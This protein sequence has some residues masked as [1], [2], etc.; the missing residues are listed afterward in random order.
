MLLFTALVQA[1]NLA[2]HVC[3][4]LSTSRRR[5]ARMVRLRRSHIPLVVGE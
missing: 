2:Y 5:V 1:S 3:G 4:W